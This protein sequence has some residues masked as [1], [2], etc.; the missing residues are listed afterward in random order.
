MERIR[1]LFVSPPAYEPL[2]A[3]DDVN[4]GEDTRDSHLTPDED[5]SIKK[6]FSWTEYSVFLA[7]GVAMLWAW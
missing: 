1:R 4:T 2:G 7:L 5:R 3:E 6:R